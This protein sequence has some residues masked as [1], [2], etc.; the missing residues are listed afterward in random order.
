LKA[1]KILDLPTEITEA[2][3]K[4]YLHLVSTDLSKE[5]IKRVVTPP[6]TYPEQKTVLAVHW[7]PEF[8]PL[9]LIM[10]R[11]SA[12]FPNREDEL[13]IPTQHN[14]LK[15]LNGYSGVEV[16]CFSHQFNRKVQLLLHFEE[17]RVT[18]DQAH[19]LKEMLN[20]TFKYRTRQLYEFLDTIIE[21]QF[22]HRLAFP[23]KKTGSDSSLINFVKFHTTKLKRLIEQ[24]ESVTRP[25]MLRNKLIRN[26]FNLLK[27]EV[28]PTL[29]ERAQI[30]LREV[31]MIVKASFPLDYFYRTSEVIE[32]A[33]SLHAGI[34]IPHPEQFWP[35]LL[36]DYDVDG[37]EV[38]N[39]Q[40]REY[41]EFLINVVNKQNKAGKYRDKPIL[42]LMGMTRTLVKRCWIPKTRIPKRQSVK[43]ACIRPGRIE[44][45]G[46]A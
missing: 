22:Q 3:Q 20:Y 36:A 5:Q 42:I 7:H 27:E 32:E 12:M 11:V 1:E 37:Y 30:F 2:D 23:A 41:T 35:I 24:N 28:S 18:D 19:V 4:K 10:E 33:R 26:Y 46:K 45:S 6:T 43:S 38:W 31:K 25:E 8:I 15:T 16:D 17:S 29:V 44:K 14:Q 34:V 21:D 13:I 9:D 40:S 39:P